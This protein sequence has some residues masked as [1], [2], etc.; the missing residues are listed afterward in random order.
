MAVRRHGLWQGTEARGGGAQV[1]VVTC[2]PQHRP[3]PHSPPP[4]RPRRY[5]PFPIR[6][7]A[8]YP[9]SCHHPMRTLRPVSYTHLRAHE[10]EADL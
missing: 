2:L 4:S 8:S 9:I 5:H 6:L 7:A 3:R 10:T 1:T